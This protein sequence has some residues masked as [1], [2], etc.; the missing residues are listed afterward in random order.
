M[1]P[2]VILA[3]WAERRLGLGGKDA[4]RAARAIAMKIAERGTKGAQVLDWLR[5]KL[6]KM[7][8]KAVTEEI[9]NGWK[10]R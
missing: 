6:V 8:Q 3:R 1:P 5:P 9:E 4:W 7:V 10:L 2:L